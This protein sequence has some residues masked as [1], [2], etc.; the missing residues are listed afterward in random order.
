MLLTAATVAACSGSTSP[1]PSPHPQQPSGQLDQA[2]LASGSPLPKGVIA[3]PAQPRERPTGQLAFV[4]DSGYSS[5]YEFDLG[6]RRFLGPAPTL[7]ANIRLPGFPTVLGRFAPQAATVIGK[8]LYVADGVGSAISA[9]P[10]EADGLG[11]AMTIQLPAFPIHL[12]PPDQDRVV[13][14]AA[15]FIIRLTTFSDGQ[16]LVVGVDYTHGVALAYTV[17]PHSGTV[18]GKLEIPVAYGYAQAAASSGATT[19]LATDQKQL[20]VME[21]KP[22][23][24]ARVL[25]LPGKPR[26][27]VFLGGALFLAVDSPARLIRVDTTSGAV[28]VIDQATEDLSGGGVATDGTRLWWTVRSPGVIREVGVQ[29]AAAG[30]SSTYSVCP[31]P[32]A[33]SFTGGVLLGLCQDG[34]LALVDRSTRRAWFTP[35][36]NFPYGLAVEAA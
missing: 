10:I 29:G 24:I 34:R 23:S 5:V 21:E 35:A 3:A 13:T 1:V 17:D 36:G 16:L 7:P 30:Q 25:S 27:A 20:L 31:N 6:R 32:T 18:T 4:V 11:A 9:I 22:L 28:R 8:T 33:L 15:P 2:P 19:V 14:S 26:G 12:R